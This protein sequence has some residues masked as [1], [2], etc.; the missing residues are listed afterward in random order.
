MGDALSIAMLSSNRVRKIRS[1]LGFFTAPKLLASL[2]EG[3]CG[4][5]LPEPP[6]YFFRG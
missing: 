3:K 2:P 1:T 5:A 4:S 6:A